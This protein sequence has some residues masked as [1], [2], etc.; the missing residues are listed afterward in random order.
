M[1]RVSCVYTTKCAI[2]STGKNRIHSSVYSVPSPYYLRLPLS[3][4]HSLSQCPV[5]NR[6]LAIHISS[7]THHDHHQ[8]TFQPLPYLDTI[9]SL[10]P[11]EYIHYPRAST[12]VLTS[13]ALD[14]CWFT[15]SPAKSK[16]HRHDHHSSDSSSAEQLVRVHRS[17]SHRH[18]TDVKVKLPSN[19]S[20]EMSEDHH[21]HHH[22]HL[23]HHHPHLHPHVP[24]PH[25]PHLHHHHLH[26]LHLH[27]IHN[28]HHTSLLHGHGRKR[29]SPPP[30]PHPQPATPQDVA[31]LHLTTTMNPST[32]PKLS[33]QPHTSAKQPASP[34]ELFNLSANAGGCV[35]S[36]ATRSW[37]IRSRLIG[38]A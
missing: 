21:H 6:A 23:H 15:L 13:R 7:L 25:I 26:P 12:L 36:L 5:T 27:P 17:P 19:L 4:S 11:Q 14:M 3:H 30:G 10:P 33:S 34:S 22:P 16:K 2:K 1:I 29:R 32:T 8:V 35:V 38:I 20:I 28:H 37:V 24:H 9:V 31:P 18:F